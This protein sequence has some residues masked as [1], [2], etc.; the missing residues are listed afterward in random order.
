[1]REIIEIE[2]AD[3]KTDWM[4]EYRK[5]RREDKVEYPGDEC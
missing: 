4:W 2:L 3:L 1:M 5:A